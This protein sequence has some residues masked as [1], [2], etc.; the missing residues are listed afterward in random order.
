MYLTLGEFIDAL[1][2]LR[3]KHDSATKIVIDDADTNWWLAIEKIDYDATTDT[4][5]IGGSYHND[6][7]PVR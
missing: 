2:A 6:N 7:N 4:V 1:E 5:S 3:R